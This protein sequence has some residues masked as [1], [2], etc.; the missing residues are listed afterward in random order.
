[1]KKF[2]L[3]LFLSSPLAAKPVGPT[4]LDQEII[5]HTFNEEYDQAKKLCQEQINLNS[6]SPKYYYYMTNIKILEYYQKISE[7]E[8]DKR[9][10]G[11]KALNKEIIDYCENVVDK[12]DES[13][14]NTENKFY[15]G[16]IYGYLARVYGVDGS[17][18]SAFKSGKKAKNIMQDV[19]ETDPKFYDAY[20]VLGMIEYYADRLSGITNFVAGV[21]GLS[22]NRETGLYYL[23]LA[24][25]KGSLTF[26]QAALT[27][28]EIHASL[29]GNDC[30]ALPYFESFL[31]RY[32][33]NKRTLNAYCHALMNVWE[34]KKAANIIK[35]DRQNLL[36]D[37]VKT[38]FYDITGESK[39]AVQYGEKA[40]GNKK[41]LWKG[42]ADA[43]CYI[44][45][46]NSWLLD[47]NTRVKKYEALLNDH[48]KKAFMLDKNRE[49]ES[50]WL[51]DLSIHV[52]SDVSVNEMENFIKSKPAFN[53]IKEFD[54]LFNSL[55]GIFYF[56]NNLYDKAEQAFNRSITF[57]DQPDKYTAMKYLIEIYMRQTAAKPKVKNLLSIIDDYDNARLKYRAKDLEKKYDL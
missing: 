51:H 24:Y 43:V 29:E 12:F 44:I 30:A 41:K 25:E 6:S 53:G 52:A 54:G 3:L 7:L 42:A 28:I 17:W 48:D 20:L 10:E 32:S 4:V 55:V 15:Y 31:K 40:L 13:K 39:L 49:K 18:W 1:M 2:W 56:N 34:L 16:S 46:F 37:Y 33:K 57:S 8:P 21:L 19:L 11:R 38:R 47:D 50:R 23:R 5:S 27:L 45:A 14:L 36:D 22:G 9:T 35:N 26:G